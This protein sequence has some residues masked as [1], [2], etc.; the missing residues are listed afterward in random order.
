MLREALAL[1]D[2]LC[3]HISSRLSGCEQA[4]GLTFTY[5]VFLS[6]KVP[7]RGSFAGDSE[8]A[9][10]KTRTFS[11]TTLA[12]S[13]SY[14]SSLKRR[15]SVPAEEGEGEDEHP[16]S[17]G[18]KRKTTHK[19]C[20]S[21][22]CVRLA[23]G[24]LYNFCLRHGG[25]YRCLVPGCSKSAYSTKY[26]SRHGGGPRCQFP[27]GCGKGAISNSSF[28]R[29]HG[30]GRRCQFPNC[31]QGSRAGYDYCLAHGGYTP[32]SFA[33]CPCPALHGGQFCRQHNSL[34][35]NAYVEAGADAA[36]STNIFAGAFPDSHNN[37][38][39]L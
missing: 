12:S 38:A 16:T 31:T 20:Q 15:I 28:C 26:C 9:D 24:P 32:C 25:G 6:S 39:I 21:E 11:S 7:T 14:S 36:I 19:P 18:K 23:H 27:G 35:P 3:S 30:G 5:P 33:Q 4:A 13:G 37:N 1:Q 17:G 22:G 2:Q 29:R 8:Y 34:R 10:A